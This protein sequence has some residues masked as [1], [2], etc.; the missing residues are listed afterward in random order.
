MLLGMIA[1]TAVDVAAVGDIP[2]GNLQAVLGAVVGKAQYAADTA[3]SA[4]YKADQAT[5]RL[6]AVE[7]KATDASTVAYEAK[8]QLD[9]YVAPR[10]GKMDAEM[11]QVFTALGMTRS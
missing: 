8:G 11:T 4:E 5:L 7:G 2:A 10:V 3:G 6:D 1:A 9:G